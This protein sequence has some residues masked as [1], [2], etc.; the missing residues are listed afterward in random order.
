[1]LPNPWDRLREDWPQVKWHKADLGSRR[2]ET[3][4]YDDGRIEIL[5]HHDLTQVARRAALAHELEH[6]DWGAPCHT[7]RASNEARVIAATARYLLPDLEQI[8]DAVHTYDLR[9]AAHELWVP[10]TVLVDRLNGLTDDESH[11]VH[12]SKIEHA[13]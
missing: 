7:L 6:L 4:W 5:T 8:R 12:E 1:V 11:Y 13:A 3:R 9:R 2:G 10:F